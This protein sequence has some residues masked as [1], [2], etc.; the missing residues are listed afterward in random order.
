MAY[1][2]DPVMARKLLKALQRTFEVLALQFD[3]TDAL[4]PWLEAVAERIHRRK[5]PRLQRVELLARWGD[6]DE[7]VRNPWSDELGALFMELEENGVQNVM[8]EFCL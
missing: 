1:T 2:F 7:R 4:E 3:H 8:V 5:I 6:R